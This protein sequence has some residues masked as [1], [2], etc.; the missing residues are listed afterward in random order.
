ME[1]SFK[2]ANLAIFT[3][4]K[5]LIVANW[6]PVEKKKRKR[7]EKFSLNKFLSPKICKNEQQRAKKGCFFYPGGPTLR[8]KK[9]EK[10]KEI[11]LGIFLL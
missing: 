2:E 11:K 7:K 9:K 10:K 1:T 3:K 8:E 6:I 4:K 5:R